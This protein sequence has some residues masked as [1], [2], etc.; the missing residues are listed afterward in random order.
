MSHPRSGDDHS[1]RVD[2]QHFIAKKLFDDK[3]F[4]RA[5]VHY[6]APAW[7]GCCLDKAVMAEPWL[8]SGQYSMVGLRVHFMAV[9]TRLGWTMTSG[10]V[11][12]LVRYGLVGLFVAG[13]D[14]SVFALLL[15]GIGLWYV[16]AHTISRTV[17]GAAGFVLNRRWT[18]GREG[19]ADLGIQAVKFAMVYLCS[20]TASSW[21]LYVWVETFRL[22]PVRAKL[23]AE[24]TVFLLNFIV[25]RLWAF[26][27]PPL[28]SQFRVSPAPEPFTPFRGGWGS[29]DP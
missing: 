27:R 6:C 2:S 29:A 7:H 23:V 24:G 19:R 13:L 21:L 18:F 28:T 14:L 3:R 4:R 8:D 15:S 10:F 20:Y 11:P 26:G 1:R 12:E 25:L 16:Y 5:M 17:G 9:M 22:S